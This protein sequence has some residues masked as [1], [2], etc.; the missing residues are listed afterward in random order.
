MINLAWGGLT[1]GAIPTSRL[2]DVS[3]REDYLEPTAAAQWLWMRTD[4][5]AATGVWINPAPGS[6]C[7]RSRATQDAFY[8]SYR[9][10]LAG[11]PYAPVAAV[12]GTSNHGWARAIDITGYEGNDT[13]TSPRTGRTYRVNLRVW[14]WLLAHAHEYG[15]DWATGD[16]SGEAWH[17]ESLTPPGTT[18]AGDITGT[19]KP[20]GT[21]FMK[22]YPNTDWLAAKK[23]GRPIAPGTRLRLLKSNTNKAQNLIGNPGP[24]SIAPHVAGKG[25]AAGDSIQLTLKFA[26]AK[27]KEST[28]YPVIGVADAQ[29]NIA[30]S[31]SF[32]RETV[33]G[34]SVY[35][36]VEAN[37]ANKKTGTITLFA[38]DAYLFN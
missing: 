16:S 6:S 9:S 26:D 27:G 36:D 4:L 11:G 20:K 1:N 38:C 22:H 14:N 17:W 15:F 24:Y 5:H 19:V 32:L 33:S 28:H 7:N 35:C 18:V 2:V 13:W 30:I 31:P 34:N 23:E 12:P 21:K 29:G 37:K 8:A 3:G 10:Y 25:F